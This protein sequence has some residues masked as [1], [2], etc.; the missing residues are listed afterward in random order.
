MICPKC[1]IPLDGHGSPDSNALSDVM[2]E[3]CQY[4]F[5]SQDLEGQL[6]MALELCKVGKS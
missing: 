1:L 5:D 6:D 4:D 3:D 2:C